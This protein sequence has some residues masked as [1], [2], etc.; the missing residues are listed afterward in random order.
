[1]WLQIVVQTVIEKL[2]DL[3]DGLGQCFGEM[4]GGKGTG[5]VCDQIET[6]NFGFDRFCG[7]FL[8]QEAHEEICSAWSGKHALT[9]QTVQQLRRYLVDVILWRC[10]VDGEV[11]CHCVE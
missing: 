2:R 8:Q 7:E 11:S 10:E 9:K 5:N 3:G 6:L 4:L 1:M